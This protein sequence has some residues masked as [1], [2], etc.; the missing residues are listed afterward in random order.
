M[1]LFLTISIALLFTGA[2]FAQPLF[3][4]VDAKQSGINFT[5]NIVETDSLHIMKYEY[6]YNG[7][8]IGV[9]DFNNDG[10]PDIFISGNAVE[11]ALYLN[12]GGLQ[13]KNITAA[14]GIKY[15]STWATGVSIADINGDGLD[16]IY[17]SHSGYYPDDEKKLSNELLI[18]QGVSNGVP[19][20]KEMA[21]EYAL[22]LPGTQS[23]QAV[24]FDYDRDGDL[25]MFQVNHS[26]HTV[27]PFLNTRKVRSVPDMKHG[28]RLFRQDRNGNEIKFTDVTLTAGILNNALNFGL[29]ATVSDL[30]N[31][32]WPDI[33]TTSDYTETDCFY[34]NNKNG[35]F[36]E[37]L[38]KSFT[39]VSKYSMGSDIAD[40]NN[41]GLPDVVT[42]DMLPEDNHR[43]KLLKGPDEYD[44]Y[45]LLIDSGYYHQQMRNMLH[46]NMGL[47][48][49][50]TVRFSE[51]GQLA[52]I[53]NTD[54]SWA[55]LFADLDNDG[56]KDLFVTNGYLRDFT[57]L[58]FLK[59]TVANVQMEEAKKGNFNF[60]TFDLVKKMPSNKLS[61]YVF[62][63]NRDLK[64][65]DVTTSWGLHEPAI[66]NS[67]VYADLDNDGDLDII[68]GR[69]NE[70]VVLYKNEADQ[71]QDAHFLKIK[72]N[73]SGYNTGAIGSKAIVFTDGEMQ[74][75]EKYPVRGYQ[76]SVSSELLFGVG[77]KAKIDSL[78]IV[79]PNGET[80]IYKDLIADS[81]YTFKQSPG[82]KTDASVTRP[83]FAEVTKES[84]IEFRHIENDFIDFKDEVL[85]PYQLSR[86]GPALAA[87]DVNGDGLS[88]FFVG[89]A[90]GQEAALYIQI[91]DGQFRSS[92]QAA[93]KDDAVSED[94]N[95]IFFDA[96][97]DGDQDLYVVSGGNE[98]ETGSPEYQDRLYINNGKGEFS[99]AANALPVMPGSKNGIAAADFD[100]D[101]DIDLFVGGRCLA[102]SYPL[103][104]KSYLLEN[105]S[106]NGKIIFEDITNTIPALI[107]PGMVSVAEW[108]DLDGDKYP[109]L[110]IG[111]DW[112]SV[113]LFK[114]EKGRLTEIT[115]EA[116]LS[117]SSGMWASLLV[118]D[119]DGDGDMDIIAG[120]SGTNLPFRASKEKPMEVFVTDID[121]NGRI[122]PLICYDIQGKSYPV[123]SRDE[124]LDQVTPM[125]KKFVYY[126]DY[127]DVTV[128]NILSKSALKNAKRMVCE[129]LQTSVFIN[130]GKMRF[131][132]KVLPV[133]A[134]FSKVNGIIG[135]DMDN[136]GNKDIL[137][138]GNFYPY[139]VRLGRND[140]SLGLFM[141][142]EKDQFK[143]VK[144][145][146][147]GF[148]AG[149][150]V[151]KMV[152][153]DGK[154]ILLARNDDSMQLFRITK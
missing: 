137:L 17:I 127:A 103:P 85:L 44:Q 134:Q 79:W 129:I 13:F 72:L 151:R 29:S 93:W 152:M 81:S 9:G 121:K 48:K 68:V 146:A 16:D 107:E 31:D 114:N 26:N 20:F 145:M 51:I 108:K 27:N 69:N 83:L 37:S 123:A 101:G 140:A 98:Y 47:D 143:A 144:P 138:A 38:K 64:F 97:K 104:A 80:S 55:G 65:E 1:R 89:G 132:G 139:N 74:M 32:G 125:R 136:D 10:L 63:N 149:G 115:K 92:P 71:K 11:P 28:N 100:G 22:D 90:I 88:D 102:G 77:G 110:I 67:A 130:D 54:W 105:R 60:K 34:V 112:M 116:G 124:L 133:E 106:V 87:A 45:H 25:D 82:K 154:Y 76:S 50:G 91:T 39:H 12:T 53:S 153:L 119:Y 33:Y 14:A 56:W 49:D 96:D 6:L 7:H 15:N 36:T 113:K 61:S 43:Q 21:V 73:G 99:K 23:T 70:P 109:E 35:T 4:R 142:G 57:D 117:E 111:G 18:N 41:D 2:V 150:D 84:G 52:G 122:D 148:F 66:S 135:E 95:A 128:N 126:K 118:T 40:Y 19:V 46:L 147:S 30:N 75:M 131:T 8:G 86:D 141:K 3:T 120:N 58:D 78:L 94:V 62:K 24:F 5:N 42:L 59:Y